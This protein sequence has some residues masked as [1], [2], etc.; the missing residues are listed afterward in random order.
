MMQEYL[1]V[2]HVRTNVLHVQMSQLVI[3]V[4][5]LVTKTVFQIVFVRMDI[6][7]LMVHNC[8]K[9]VIQVV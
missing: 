6:S 2:H 9:L 8:V 3:L 7:M 5:T 4:L 1:L